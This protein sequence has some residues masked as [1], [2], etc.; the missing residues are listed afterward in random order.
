MWICKTRD[1][2]ERG[3]GPE[4]MIPT[5]KWASGKYEGDGGGGEV[6]K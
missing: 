4:G 5:D 2:S 1:W 3:Q 6:V